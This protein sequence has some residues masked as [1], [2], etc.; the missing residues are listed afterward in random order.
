MKDFAEHSLMLG[1][2]W[3]NFNSLELLIRFYLAK[4]HGENDSGLDLKLGEKILASEL[5]QRSTTRS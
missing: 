1:K 3:T 5:L 4:K 2:F